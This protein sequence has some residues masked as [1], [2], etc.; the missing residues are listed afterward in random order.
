MFFVKNDVRIGGA[1][2]VW[3]TCASLKYVLRYVNR[4]LCNEI[5]G[6]ARDSLEPR[7]KVFESLVCKLISLQ[8][9]LIRTTFELIDYSK[10]FSL[11]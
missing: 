10:M 2:F 3:C 4:F 5:F 11:H 1:L 7:E 9:K 6:R 8:N